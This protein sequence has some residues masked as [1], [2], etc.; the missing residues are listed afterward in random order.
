MH[1]HLIKAIAVTAAGS[2]GL[3]AFILPSKARSQE[4]TQSC[5]TALLNSKNRIEQGREITLRT[6]ITDG[7]KKYPDHPNSRPI[8][9]FIFLDFPGSCSI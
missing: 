2:L 9:I 1:K 8:F 4:I 6:H 3:S 5:E 7:S